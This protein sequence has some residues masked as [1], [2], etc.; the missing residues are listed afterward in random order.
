M[1][2][3]NTTEEDIDECKI[4]IDNFLS[5]LIAHRDKIK[6]KSQR[7]DFNYQWSLLPNR[8]VFIEKPADLAIKKYLLKRKQNISKGILLNE[9]SSEVNEEIT[10]QKVISDEMKYVNE[11][12]SNL[13]LKLKNSTSSAAG[14]ELIK[15]FVFDI[16]GRDTD[17][18]ILLEKKLG[19]KL[20]SK[21]VV[22]ITMQEVFCLIFISFLLVYYTVMRKENHGK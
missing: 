13:A 18:A 6:T 7:K 3:N 19:K 2:I 21:K 15:L 8:S 11:C 10:V 12:S 17:E 4:S 20:R 16:L 1:R 14:A 9:L 5:M 22:S